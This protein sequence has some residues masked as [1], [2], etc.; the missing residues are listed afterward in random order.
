[1]R[2]QRLREINTLAVLESIIAGRGESS[3]ADVATATKL[4]R[5][6]V[7]ALVEGLLAAGLVE[8]RESVRAGTGRPKT[9]LIASSKV[10]GL[11]AEVAADHLRVL[12]LGLD[13]STVIDEAR[14]TEVALRSPEQ[15]ALQLAELLRSCRERLPQ[16]TRISA[17]TV[18]LPARISGDGTCVA[19]GP[20]IGWRDVPFSK[21]VADAGWSETPVFLA[22][23]ANLAAHH[24]ADARPGE[25]FLFLHGE[26]GIG[27][28]IVVDGTPL[29]GTHGWAG[30]LGHLPLVPGGARCGCG[31]E[32]CLEAYVGFHALRKRAGLPDSTCLDT[33]A[34]RL[35]AN[36]KLTDQIGHEI[37]TAL[38][39]AFTLLDIDSLV[40]SG[41]FAP[42]APA[43]H[44]SLSQALSAHS[45]AEQIHISPAAQSRGVEVLGAAQ[46]SL[47]RVRADIGDWLSVK[48]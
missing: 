3:R 25:S 39:G 17:L 4:T 1:M 10:V 41:Y 5:P 8:E 21:L 24:E 14:H 15:T 7:S 23:D 32:G 38:A 46:A 18:S 30:E 28:A 20:N 35:S 19:S 34:G 48:D 47:Q 22:N 26:T 43:L 33:I 44:K 31:L 13:G 36:Q 9:P 37:G 45:F 29:P 2:V 27:G 16:G 6:T 40:L 11:G 42:L 12:G